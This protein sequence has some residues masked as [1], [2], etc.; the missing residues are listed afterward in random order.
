MASASSFAFISADFI[1]FFVF[2]F[3]PEACVS[4]A[5]LASAEASLV[6][7]GLESPYSAPDDSASLFSYDSAAFDSTDERAD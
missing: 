2:F 5:L 3:Y 6:E 1:F 7:S 4:S